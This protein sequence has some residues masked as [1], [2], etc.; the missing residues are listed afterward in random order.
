MPPKKGLSTNFEEEN[1]LNACPTSELAVEKPLTGF[2]DSQ[3]QIDSFPDIVKCLRL[4]P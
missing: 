2:S 1:L 3:E 4:C